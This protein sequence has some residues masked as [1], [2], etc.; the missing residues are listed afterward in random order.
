MPA[1]SWTARMV[2]PVMVRVSEAEARLVLCERPTR[3]YVRF[4]IGQSRSLGPSRRWDT[5]DACTLGDLLD[6]ISGP[7]VRLH[8]APAG[9]TVPVT[10]VLL[11]DAHAPLP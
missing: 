5:M 6:T 4:Q 8:T 11:H 2:T 10:E 9:L 7:S 3:A 1:T